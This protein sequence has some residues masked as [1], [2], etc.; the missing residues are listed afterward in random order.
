MVQSKGLASS[1]PLKIGTDELIEQVINGIR[2]K[3]GNDIVL[4]DLRSINSSLADLFVVCHGDSDVHV[5]AIAG[6]VIDEVE[7]HTGESPV[8]KEGFVNA[9]WVLLDYINVVVHIFRKEQRE[10][11]GIEEFW[12]DADTQRIEDNIT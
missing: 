7:K 3:K 4:I 10:F 6:S 1:R 11:Y 5:K 8:Y 2:E 12:A 9:D